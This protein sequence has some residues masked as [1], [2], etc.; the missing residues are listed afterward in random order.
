MQL[1]PVLEFTG[2]DRGWIG[3]NPFIYLDTA[4]MQALD[5]APKASIRE[6]VED[7]VDWLLSNRWV[8]DAAITSTTGPS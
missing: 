8:L 7:T 2:G 5:W 1:D 3:D 4:A 6:A